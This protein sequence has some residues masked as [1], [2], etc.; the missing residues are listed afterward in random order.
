MSWRPGPRPRAPVTQKWIDQ[1]SDPAAGQD[2][3]DF[4]AA[5]NATYAQ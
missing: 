3:I 5:Q 1:L 4:I 2:V